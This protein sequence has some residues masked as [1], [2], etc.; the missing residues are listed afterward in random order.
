MCPSR[1]TTRNLPAS[2]CVQRE[3]VL[4]EIGRP[5]L[6]VSRHF[7]KLIGNC[8]FLKFHSVISPSKEFPEVNRTLIGDVTTL[9]VCMSLQ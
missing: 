9:H 8:I 4:Q 7:C 1:A 3:R 5:L 2:S 6:A